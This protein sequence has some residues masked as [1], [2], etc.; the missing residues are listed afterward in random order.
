LKHIAHRAA[1]AEL[2]T[3]ARVVWLERVHIVTFQRNETDSVGNELIV[4]HRGVLFNLNHIN[5]HGWHF[6][7]DDSA[8]SVCHRQV[9]VGQLKLHLVTRLL[10]DADVQV[11]DFALCSLLFYA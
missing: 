1:F 4:E 11:A 5:G 2:S 3:R 6:T 10:Q 9:N 7:D 8:Q